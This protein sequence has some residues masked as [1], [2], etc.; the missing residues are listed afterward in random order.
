MSLD[1]IDRVRAGEESPFALQWRVEQF[2]YREG[3]LLDQRRYEEWLELL[4]PDIV[5]TMP[6][7]VDRLRQHVKRFGGKPDEIMLFDD[8]FKS[9]QMRVVRL[10]SGVCWAE[11]PPARVRHMISN[12][13]VARSADAEDELNVTSV[14][15]VYVSRM[16]ESGILFSGERNDVL[17]AAGSDFRVKRRQII[18]D[19]TV[20]LS[21]NLTIFF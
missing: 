7:R 11:D 16:E 2:L 15:M 12:V 10:N 21:N 9:L 13:Q 4:D 18:G 5:Y 8:D 3:A 19:Q 6:L 17:K 1:M 20:M 14:F